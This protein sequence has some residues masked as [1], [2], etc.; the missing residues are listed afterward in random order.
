[1]EIEG[2][3]V[4]GRSGAANDYIRII[5]PVHFFPFASATI[6]ART[7][8]ILFIFFVSFFLALS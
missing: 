1:V 8:S 3:W 7:A 5:R 6:Q 2:Q 4:T